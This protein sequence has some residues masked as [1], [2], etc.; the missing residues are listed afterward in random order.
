MLRRRDARQKKWGL[1]WSLLSWLI[2]RCV[3]STGER[4]GPRHSV[5]SSPAS[6]CTFSPF[7]S[8]T[9]PPMCLLERVPSST[10]PGECDVAS[11]AHVHPAS[12][13]QEGC[14]KLWSRAGGDEQ[15]VRMDWGGTLSSQKQS[16]MTWLPGYHNHK[17]Y[18]QWSFWASSW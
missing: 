2:T 17:H 11:A 9:S 5:A 7:P 3:I 12:V 6:S 4:E 13:R 15:I 8:P 1:S 10:H 14:V 16:N 18:G